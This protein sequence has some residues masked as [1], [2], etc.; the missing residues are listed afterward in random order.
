MATW[1]RISR[2]ASKG[3]L[4]SRFCRPS[5]QT[6]DRVFL[7]PSQHL[8]VSVGKA[9][10]V[11]IV[12][13]NVVGRL[14]S[15][16]WVSGSSDARA[17]YDGSTRSRLCD[18]LPPDRI[19]SC[20][21]FCATAN[22]SFLLSLVSPTQHVSKPKKSIIVLTA[23]DPKAADALPWNGSECTEREFSSSRVSTD[24]CVKALKAW[25]SRIAAQA[26]ARALELPPVPRELRPV[27]RRQRRA[28]AAV[29]SW[30]G[31]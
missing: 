1:Q 20:D 27:S 5:G 15:A 9:M 3:A 23:T 6:R 14:G 19:L 17:S 13:S 28:L 4:R 29:R 12:L 31:L 8:L 22:S 18:Q 16:R 7:F 21:M 26:L 2:R 24:G 25:V 11:A 10:T 30:A